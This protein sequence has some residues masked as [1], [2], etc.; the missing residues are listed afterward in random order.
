MSFNNRTAL[1]EHATD[2]RKLGRKHPDGARLVTEVC[3]CGAVRSKWSDE[4][5]FSLWAQPESALCS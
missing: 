2:D 5:Y 4:G 3:T 1:H